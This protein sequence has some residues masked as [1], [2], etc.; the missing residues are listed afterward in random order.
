MRF[1]RSSLV[2]KLLLLALV[3]YAAVTLVSLQEQLEATRA[4][5]AALEDSIAAGEQ[6]NRRTEDDINALGTDIGTVQ[7][8][9]DRLGMVYPWELVFIDIGN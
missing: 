6:K 9:R 3:I 2:T 7:V 4:E 8:A 1:K 5:E